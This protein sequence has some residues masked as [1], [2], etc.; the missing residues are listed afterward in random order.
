MSQLTEHTH[1]NTIVGHFS[2][3]TLPASMRFS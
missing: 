3:T 1:N 2:D